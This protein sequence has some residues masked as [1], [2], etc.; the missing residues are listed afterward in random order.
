MINKAI[1]FQT[2]RKFNFTLVLALLLA[3]WLVITHFHKETNHSPDTLC[4]LCLAG[5]QINHALDSSPVVFYLEPAPHF[6]FFVSIQERLQ[7]FY[8]TFRSR[9]PPVFL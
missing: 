5:K 6:D 2:N 4:S 8:P 1:S 7:Q 9:A 3:Q